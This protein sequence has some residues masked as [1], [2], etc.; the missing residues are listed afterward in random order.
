M[1]QGA[2]LYSVCPKCAGK[3][4]KLD[5]GI[6][7]DRCGEVKEPEFRAVVSVRIDDGTA[8]INAVAYGKEAEKII[9]LG[10]EE[11]KKQCG[12]RGAAAMIEE[13]QEMRGT[14]ISIIGRAKQ[15][16]YSSGLELVADFVEIE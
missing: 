4:Q 8:Q 11:L 10:R 7:C 14:K 2:L 9:G 13:L 15:N 5:E 12:E 16:S 6:I 1:N 3:L